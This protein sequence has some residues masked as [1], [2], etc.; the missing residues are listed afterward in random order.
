MGHDINCDDNVFAID[1]NTCSNTTNA[2]VDA[3]G[4]SALT[5]VRG[6]KNNVPFKGLQ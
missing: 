6:S 4:S 1:A 3:K 5:A 2:V